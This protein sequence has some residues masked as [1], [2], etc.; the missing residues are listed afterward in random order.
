[1]ERTEQWYNW[2]ELEKINDY[3]PPPFPKPTD[4]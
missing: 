4:S 3:I 1:M 2:K